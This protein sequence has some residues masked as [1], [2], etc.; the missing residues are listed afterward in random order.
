MNSAHQEC[1]ERAGFI[2]KYI[3]KPTCILNLAYKPYIYLITSEIYI[4]SSLY[5]PDSY[6][7]DIYMKIGNIY[8]EGNKGDSISIKDSINYAIS[9]QG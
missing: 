3:L 9:Q 5:L 8:I 4:K 7:R 2:N 1:L 6:I